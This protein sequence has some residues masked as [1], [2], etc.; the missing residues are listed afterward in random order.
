MLIKNPDTYE[1][2][3]QKEGDALALPKVQVGIVG[4]GFM[5]RVHA[6]AARAASANVRGVVASGRP[7][8]DPQTATGAERTYSSLEEML[9]DELIEVVHVCVPNRLHVAVTT[10]AL[11]AGKHV[12]CEKPLATT[13]TDAQSL[14]NEATLLGKLGAVPFVYRFH[15]MVREMR[16]RIASGQAG[17]IGLIHGSYLQDWLAQAQETD[18]RVNAE[19]GGASR[20]FADVGSHW[21]DLLE[22][23]TGDRIVAISAQFSTVRAQRVTPDGGT[24]PVNTEDSATLQFKTAAGVIGV[25]SASQV[26]AG[27]KNRLLLEVSGTDKS[28]AFDQEDPEQLWVGDQEGHRVFVRDPNSLSVEAARLAVLPAGHAQGYQDC[29][30]AFVADAYAQIDGKS[31]DGLPTFS[32]GVRAATIVDAVLKSVRANGAWTSISNPA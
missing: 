28:F 15:P 23:V 25:F 19:V 24:T 16:H 27:R 20:V 29:F 7:G 14:L 12:I 30:N 8:T 5:G 32:D 11:R 26:A 2:H 9:A 17:R 1:R 18:W 22:F 3:T 10:A 6:K 31:I 4:A 21:C 13:A